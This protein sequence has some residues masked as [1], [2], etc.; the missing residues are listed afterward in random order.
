M[1][2]YSIIFLSLIDS[3]FLITNFDLNWL[4]QIFRFL[5]LTFSSHKVRSISDDLSFI[6]LFEKSTSIILAA[7][8]SLFTI[9]NS[10]SFSHPISVISLLETFRVLIESGSP[11]AKSTTLS[12]IEMK[13]SSPRFLFDK[14]R[15]VLPFSR[16]SEITS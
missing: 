9:K 10:Q 3:N 7:A 16:T 11:S 1:K 12:I 13:N 4:L 6:L 5:K 2:Y 8:P 15:V 14:S